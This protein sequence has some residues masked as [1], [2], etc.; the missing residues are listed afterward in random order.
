MS[1]QDYVENFLR[2]R[3]VEKVD[4]DSQLF[5]ECSYQEHVKWYQ[6]GR[7]NTPKKEMQNVRNVTE[8]VPVVI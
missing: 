8:G 1:L 7:I 3:F 2:T 6:S 5:L 4:F